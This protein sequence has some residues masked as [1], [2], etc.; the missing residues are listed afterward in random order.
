MKKTRAL[1]HLLSSGQKWSKASALPGPVPSPMMLTIGRCPYEVVPGTNVCL[2]LLY[3]LST[4]PQTAWMWGPGWCPRSMSCLGTGQSVCMDSSDNHSSLPKNLYLQGSQLC[5]TEVPAKFKFGIL[6]ILAM[7]TNV[8]CILGLGRTLLKVFLYLYSSINPFTD[9]ID[10]ILYP[11]QG[12]R[13]RGTERVSNLASVF[14]QISGSG[15]IQ[16]QP[17]RLWSYAPELLW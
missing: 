3:P 1:C 8:Y 16:T 11:F 9:L 17:A 4:V 13:N 15:G 6:E 5:L 14:Q 12:W 7:C 2:S 10:S